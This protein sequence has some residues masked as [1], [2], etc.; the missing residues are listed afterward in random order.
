MIQPSAINFT[1]K[2][3]HI[4]LVLLVALGYIVTG[5]LGLQMP[6]VGD[7]ITLVWLP[8]GIALGA[9]LRWGYGVW[10]GVY[11]GALIVNLVIGSP[12]P[13]A[14]GIAIGNTLGPLLAWWLMKRVGFHS[15]FDQRKDILWFFCLTL[16]GMIFSA[17]GGVINLYTAGLL[18]MAAMSSAWLTWWM[19]DSVGALIAAPLLLSLTRRNIRHLIAHSSEFALWLSLSGILAWVA[20]VH[21]F[22]ARLPIAFTTLP[23]LA[24][25]ALRFGSTGSALAGLFF[26]IFAIYG[27]ATG[28]GTFGVEDMQ[29]RMYLLWS[30]MAVVVLTLLLIAL[31]QDERINVE[32]SL[33]ESQ[34]KLGSL[35]EFSPIGIAL[36]DM[37]GRYI[38]FNKAFVNICGY[39]EDELKAMDYWT[40]TPKKYMQE[41]EHL[42]E[43]L[44]QTGRYGPYEKE[45]LRKDGSLVPL[46][47]NGSLVYDRDGQAFIWSLVEDIS[48]SR[49]QQ[50][51]LQAAKE[52]AEAANNA[53]SEFLA[54]MSHEIRTPLNGILGLA[55][56]LMIPGIDEMRRLSYAST[57]LASGKTLMVL[58]NDILDMSKIEAGKFELQLHP[59]HPAQVIQQVSELFAE[60]VANKGLQ[61]HDEWCGPDDAHYLIDSTRLRQMLS[62]LVSNAIKFTTQGHI[63]VEGKEVS[64]NNGTALLEFSVI[65]TGIGIPP[66]KQPLLFQP[67]S[68]ID[69][70]N[71]RENGGT[72]LGLSIVRNL[73]SMMDGEIGVDSETGYGTR[74][75]FQ[76]S[77][78]SIEAE[79]ASPHTEATPST[80]TNRL[81]NNAEVLIVDDSETN[82][83]ILQSFLDTQGVPYQTATNGK[84]AVD[85]ILK[86]SRTQLILMDCQMPI[87]DGYEATKLIRNWEKTN[88]SPRLPILAVTA[89]AFQQDQEQCLAAGMDDFLSKPIDL[90]KLKS[91]LDKWLIQSPHDSSSGR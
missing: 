45:Y 17:L 58:L 75:W 2:L 74:V 38:E 33:R 44:K 84:E 30:Y 35:F 76:I 69:A 81:D 42:L 63:R 10:P 72:G 48:V 19:G 53:K 49:Q 6:S 1:R 87:M 14:A 89:K 88:G 68:Q 41:E 4:S 15:T 59:T 20:F 32:E 82:R 36:T 60:Q 21:T 26:S 34:Q 25:A 80:K 46:R 12:L 78:R 5:W 31:L 22:E 65:D 91:L 55:Q 66:E 47:L 64:I 37:Q 90:G 24:W 23:A 11:I 9:M 39:S 83:L 73:A 8:T 70:S 16:V 61:L 85:H 67:F 51:E 62:N 54:T 77:A 50:I 79:T 71:T 7:H 52:A 29:I 56:V 13:L 57:I 86:G 43:L 27:T 3:Q 40:L 18:P 28:Q